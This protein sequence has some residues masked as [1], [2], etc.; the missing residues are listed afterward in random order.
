M[1]RRRADAEQE[2]TVAGSREGHLRT[3]LLWEGQLK[4]GRLMELFE[5]SGIRASEIL[6]S[7]RA[8]HPSWLR[9]DSRARA[10][11][12]TPAA[13]RSYDAE[14]A[15]P[16]GASLAHYVALIGL[17]EAGLDPA[18]TA[19]N[20]V[21]DVVSPDPRVFAP[22]L[23]ATQAQRAVRITYRS[24]QEPAPHERLIE[25]HA[26]TRAGPR[27][28]VRAY[29]QTH[30]DFRDFSLRRIVAVKAAAS[31]ARLTP[32]TARD[33]AWL[34][35]VK[36]RLVAHPAL[37]NAQQDLIRFEYFDNTAGRVETCRGALV[38]YLL[39]DLRVA[40]DTAKQRPPE[41]VLAV[42]NPSEVKPWLFP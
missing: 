5:L 9:W 29:S 17:P 15:A 16:R 2:S 12:A 4:R 38:P 8:T 14:R 36:V 41:H 33:E 37:S 13:Y 7:F 26:L 11:F 25:P 20:A 35:M 27:W 40:I 42:G 23:K 24:M 39:Q 30:G 28:H 22:L 34:T 6:R 19:S 3:L 31:D 21:R 18:P 32:P 10:Y 1:Q